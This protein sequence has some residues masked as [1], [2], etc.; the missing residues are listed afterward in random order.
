MAIVHEPRTRRAIHPLHAVFLAS[1]VPL[2]LGTLLSDYAY[3]STY[4]IQ[5][6]N[7]ASWLLVGA[8]VFTGL[9]LLWSFVSLLRAHRR[10]GTV[11]V[12][13]LLLLAVFVLG[14]INAFVHARDAW[15]TMPEGLILSV[16]VSVLAVA[17]TWAG[18]STLRTGVTR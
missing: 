9:A 5:W 12:T 13:F 11:L 4:H 2:F 14:L 1:S 3:T 17:A 16:I 7:F 18:F 6:S 8:M 10:K 15:G